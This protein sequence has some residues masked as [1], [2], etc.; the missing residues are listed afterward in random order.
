MLR[1]RLICNVPSTDGRQGDVALI[2]PNGDEHKVRCLIRPN[3]T[4]IGGDK[5][6]LV[7]LNEKYGD[8]QVCLAA[9]GAVLGIC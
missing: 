6:S 5:D 8:Q 1:A 7:Y 3:G 9:Q 4:D 2:E